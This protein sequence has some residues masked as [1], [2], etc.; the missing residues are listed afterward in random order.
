MPPLRCARIV[1]V[2]VFG[3]K[4]PAKPTSISEMDGPAAG[5]V[6]ARYVGRISAR[7]PGGFARTLHH[8]PF[9]ASQARAGRKA[10][11]GVLADSAVTSPAASPGA[12]RRGDVWGKRRCTGGGSPRRPSWCASLTPSATSGPPVC[13]DAAPAPKTPRPLTF[14]VPAMSLPPSR[15]RRIPGPFLARLPEGQSFQKFLNRPGASA[16]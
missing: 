7:S 15:D 13:S 14:G 12:G 4:A 16:V 11:V 9:Q 8:F 1:Q 10:V 2:R 6:A 3:G 5:V